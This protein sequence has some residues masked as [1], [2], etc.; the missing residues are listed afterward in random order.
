MRHPEIGSVAWLLLAVFPE[1]TLLPCG[2]LFPEMQWEGSGQPLDLAL[3][4]L[5]NCEINF[6]LKIT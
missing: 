4:S 3:L 2:A 1:Y 6:S 5:L